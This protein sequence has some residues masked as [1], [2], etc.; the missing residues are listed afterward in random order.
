MKVPSSSMRPSRIGVR[1]CALV[2]AALLGACASAPPPRPAPV[3]SLVERQ[4][5]GLRELGF[6][7]TDDGW[8]LSL[9]DPISF[10]FGDTDVSPDIQ[11]AAATT[12]KELLRLQIHRVRLEGHTDNVGPGDVNLA[13]SEQ[14]AK[15]VGNVFVQNGFRE[16][17]VIRAGLGA[18]RPVSANDTIEGR[19][20]NRRVE[21][22]VPVDAL[23]GAP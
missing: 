1:A 3:P 10:R 8:L 13:L 6:G 14:R 16:E 17:D 21:I 18:H 11:H 19:A 12:A 5:A 15:A 20:R 2:L 23:A 4:R 9:P 7:P 22:I